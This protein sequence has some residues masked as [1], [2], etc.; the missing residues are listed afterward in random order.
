MKKGQS[1][2]SFE[3]QSVTPERERTSMSTD[4]K[5]IV[6]RYYE[7]M[8][9]RWDLAVADEII[10]ADVTF[11]GSLAVTVRRREGF[12]EYVNLVR[13]AFPDFH[14]AVETLIAEDDKVVARLTY[15]GTH[16]GEMF[17]IAPTG[18]RVT[19]A[20][21]AIFTLAGGQVVDGWV[22]GDTLGMMRQ[23][24]AVPEPA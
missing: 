6:R 14:N 16:E 24:G 20:G 15:R 18:K 5:A 21:C 2:A 1:Y 17:G 11:R 4:N 22:L 19:Y 9:N 10:A 12:K 13:S 3:P 8:W 7:D 23:L